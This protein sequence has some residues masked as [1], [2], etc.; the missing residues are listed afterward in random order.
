MS[1]ERPQPS[2][3]S[4]LTKYNSFVKIVRLAE[5][6][7]WQGVDSS[8]QGLVSMFR[9]LRALTGGGGTHVMAPP[10]RTPVSWNTVAPE[11]RRNLPPPPEPEKYADSEAYEEA[12]SSWTHRVMPIVMKRHA[13]WAKIHALR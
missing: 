9:A 13:A 10:V 7:I 12:R 8:K 5:H 2:H 11:V 1:Q 6:E 3:L 4:R